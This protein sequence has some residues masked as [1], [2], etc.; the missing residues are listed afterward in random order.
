MSSVL[1]QDP[2]SPISSAHTLLLLEPLHATHP[3][4]PP[5]LMR[6]PQSA[7]SAYA[8]PMS[9]SPRPTSPVSQTAQAARSHRVSSIQQDSDSA[10]RQS[11]LPELLTRK[12]T[13]SMPARKDKDGLPGEYPNVSHCSWSLRLPALPLPCGLVPC[14]RNILCSVGELAL[15]TD[16]LHQ[17]AA[18]NHPLRISGAAPA[19]RAVKHR[20]PST[21]HVMLCV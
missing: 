4:S 9:A 19:A 21:I 14:P 18:P 3:A 15:L 6:R 20:F 1:T 11:R 17:S 16:G 8:P 13:A 12:R 7:S 2:L 5:A 10:R